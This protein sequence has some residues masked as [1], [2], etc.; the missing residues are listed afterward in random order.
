M[1]IKCCTLYRLLFSCMSLQKMES[2]LQCSTAVGKLSENI[3]YQT[4]KGNSEKVWTTKYTTTV[5]M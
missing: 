4:S 2:L 1:L 3:G 5:S